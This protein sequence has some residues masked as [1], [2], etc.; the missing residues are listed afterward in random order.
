MM[1]TSQSD[2]VIPPPDKRGKQQPATTS[3]ICTAETR[4]QLYCT[5]QRSDR[6]RRSDTQ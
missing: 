5:K 3:E 6:K 1:K 2:H 4:V